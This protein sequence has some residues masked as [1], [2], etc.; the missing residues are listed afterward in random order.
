MDINKNIKKLFSLTSKSDDEFIKFINKKFGGINY[1]S[2][3]N[4]LLHLLVMQENYRLDLVLCI[5][6][7]I[8]L[9]IDSNTKDSLGRT[10]LQRSLDT[11]GLD[12]IIPILRDKDFFTKYIDANSVD[13]EGNTLVHSAILKLNNYFEY[14]EIIELFNILID[15]YNFDVSKRNNNNDSILDLA[16]ERIDVSHKISL[17]F[18]ARIYYRY[19]NDEF[20]KLILDSNK[21]DL[22]NSLNLKFIVYSVSLLICQTTNP[23]N[24]EVVDRTFGCNPV[25]E[26]D[27]NNF[28]T[29]AI[30][31]GYPTSYI[32]QII[33]LTAS[34]GWLDTD[35]SKS[36]VLAMMEKNRPIKDIID[37]YIIASKYGYDNLR[38]DIRILQSHRSVF[39]FFDDGIR[40]SELYDKIR[41]DGFRIM[42]NDALRNFGISNEVHLND[43]VL[44]TFMDTTKNFRKFLK[45]GNE[46]QFIQSFCN[47]MKE[48]YSISMNIMF[49]ETISERDILTNLK[50]YLIS[51]FED[52]VNRTL[53]L[54]KGSEKNE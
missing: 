4:S 23:K 39:D 13:N 8:T 53:V 24:D 22:I 44:K 50:E 48:K 12:L 2:D 42:F 49:N 5:K 10:F 19:N 37:I 54:T 51:L 35:F 25:I 47:F 6:K 43:D 26:I 36:F 27:G 41:L 38:Q 33:E 14:D 34:I 32:L 3:G 1:Q 21:D 17:D 7:L 15:Y 52:K 28:I 46:Y 45:L 40:R 30:F 29:D 18:I 20:S 16:T 9:G 11:Y 31:K